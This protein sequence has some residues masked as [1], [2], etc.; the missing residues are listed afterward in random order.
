MPFCVRHF[1]LLSAEGTVLAEVNEHHQSRWRLDLAEPLHTR[2]IILE[3][4]ETWAA[5]PAIYEVRC[6]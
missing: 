3:I 2:A 5:L 1:R 6:Y 4:L